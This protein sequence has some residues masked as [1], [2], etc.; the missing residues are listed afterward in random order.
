MAKKLSKM[1]EREKF[2][3]FTSKKCYRVRFEAHK[4]KSL[5][6]VYSAVSVVTK[7]FKTVLGH[8]SWVELSVVIDKKRIYVV[9]DCS[10]FPGNGFDAIEEEVRK[11]LHDNGIFVH[12]KELVSHCMTRSII[13]V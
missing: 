4:F 5:D 7:D 13:D 11:Q 10:N 3:A 12:A 2:E 6:N 1:T 9:G 8:R